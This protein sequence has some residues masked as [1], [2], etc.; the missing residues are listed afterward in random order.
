MN[1]FSIL[2]NKTIAEKDYYTGG[3]LPNF[4]LSENENIILCGNID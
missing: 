2:K 1:D 3:L 4:Y